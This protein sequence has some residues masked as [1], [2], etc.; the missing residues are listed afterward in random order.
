MAH[1]I[2]LETNKESEFF[3]KLKDKYINKKET[4]YAIQLLK[5][6]HNIKYKSIKECKM[7]SASIKII[8]R[9]NMRLVNYILNNKNSFMNNNKIDVKKLFKYILSRVN[10]IDQTQNIYRYILRERQGNF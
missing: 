8:D 4:S 7:E 3:K 6:T 9:E 5:K 10:S 2:S 1:T